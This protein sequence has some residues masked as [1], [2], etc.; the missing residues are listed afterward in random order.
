MKQFFVSITRR[1]AVIAIATLIAG[2][3]HAVTQQRLDPKVEA[4][5]SSD[6]CQL[7][8]A[9]STLHAMGKGAVPLLIEAIDH[10]DSVGIT[11]D[12]PRNSV[13]VPPLETP[14]GVVAAYTIELILARS[15]LRTSADC[16][17]L[18]VQDDYLYYS[19]VIVDRDRQRR[20]LDLR[21]VQNAYRT[22][23]QV[24]TD[25]SLETLR[26]EWLAGRGPLS[27]SSYRW[28]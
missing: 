16:D 20:H 19:G 14:L 6:T 12:N 24:A 13:L 4:L 15:Q 22:W 23:W 21:S 7:R 27:S 9:I 26:E 5:R 17:F 8:A 10:T 28:R 3:T 25:K 2:C 1:S 11:L 18:L